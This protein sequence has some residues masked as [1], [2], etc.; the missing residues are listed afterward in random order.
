MG[1]RVGTAATGGVRSNM[2]L[3]GE[4]GPEVVNLAPGSHVRSNPDS[5][6]L[7][8]DGG[9]VSG[10]VFEFKSSGRRADDLLLEIMRDAIH[11]R[12]GDPVLVLG[13]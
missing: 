2:T 12:G 7:M 1:Q 10:A 4:H 3:V 13:G 8:K 5:K 11:Q 6:R 9:G